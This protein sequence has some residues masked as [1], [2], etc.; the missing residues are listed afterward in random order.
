MSERY[1]VAIIGTGPAGLSAAITLKIRNKKI[2]LFGSATLSEKV[3]KAHEIQNYLGLPAI[4]G[5]DL[6]LKFMEH[7][8][9]MDISVT[10]TSITSIY[11]MG[12]YF[13]MI[14][15]KNE[16]FEAT[17]VILATGVHFGKPYEG[18]SE[19]LGRGVSYCATCDAPLYKGKSVAVVASSAKEEKEA[20][21]LAE[22]AQ[23]V[24][25]VPLYKDE[26][27]F[28]DSFAGNITIVQDVPVSIQGEKKAQKLVLKKQEIEV[29]GI[30]ILRDSIAPSQLI[31]GIEM[32]GNHVSVNRKMETSIP[33]VFACG[34]IAG[35][36]YQY[37]KSAGEGN[38]AALSAVN[39]LSIAGGKK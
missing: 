31:Q 29:D 12:S 18:E 24:V 16:I 36:P 22:I 13:S 6:Q 20:A 33:G 30:F 4:K 5:S 14:S 38:V 35:A 11:P 34:D 37:I 7:L 17:S 28:D 26:V 2:I 27:S 1:D 10:E 32:D 39:Y 21:F 3:E 8:K 25:Y 15:N 19:F 23:S 9:Q